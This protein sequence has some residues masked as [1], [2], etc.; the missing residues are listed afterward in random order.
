M[1][2]ESGLPS[3][4]PLLNRFTSIGRV[5]DP[6]YRTNALIMALSA[7]GGLVSMGLQLLAGQDFGTAL[8]GGVLTGLA[9]LLAWVFTREV[10]PDHAYSAFISAG[11]ALAICLLMGPQPLALLPLFA[12]VVA[13]RM[14]NRIVGPPFR[15]ADSLIALAL[16][17]ALAAAG[18]GIATVMLG[19]AFA[20]DGLLKP[21]LRRHLALAAIAVIAGVLQV[22]GQPI[23]P[24]G[25]HGDAANIIFGVVLAFGFLLMSTNH[26]TSRADIPSYELSASR[27]QAGMV[28]AM[29]FALISGFLQGEGALAAY[30]PLWTAF[31][32]TALYRLGML[33]RERLRAE[34]P[35][36]AQP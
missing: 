33:A 4:T 34:P 27:M 21:P 24:P 13:V 23:T 3:D 8:I 6:R 2:P 5:L 20:L 35:P 15:W 30:L 18:D 9:T 10:D 17:L 25:L 19:I 12:A 29:G 16:A 11:L 22:A 7:A 32:G 1:R 26:I 14:I 36:P 31:T 28:W